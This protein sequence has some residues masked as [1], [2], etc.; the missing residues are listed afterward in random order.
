MGGA[1]VEWWGEDVEVEWHEAEVVEWHEEE[2]EAG[3]LDG[4]EAEEG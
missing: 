3:W 2:E 1:V 4:V